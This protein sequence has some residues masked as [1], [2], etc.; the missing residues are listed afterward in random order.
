MEKDEILVLFP[1]FMEKDSIARQHT[2]LTFF[3]FY[4]QLAPHD[5]ATTSQLL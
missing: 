2:I 4:V 5:K 3:F 1:D